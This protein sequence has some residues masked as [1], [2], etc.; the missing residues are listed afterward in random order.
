VKTCFAARWSI[1]LNLCVAAIAMNAI[2]SAS[3]GQEAG[4]PTAIVR[5][6]MVFLRT[7]DQD[8]ASM[9][10]RHPFGELVMQNVHDLLVRQGTS[11]SNSFVTCSLCAPSRATFLTGL[12]A[13]NHGVT[14]NVLP[15]GGYYRLDHS[16]T[17]PVWLQKAGYV[18]AHI[19]KYI[20]QYGQKPGVDP[21]T[22]PEV[23]RGATREIPPG[24]TRWFTSFWFSYKNYYI[25]DD[26]SIVHYG[27]DPEDYFT[28][29]MARKAVEFITHPPASGPF[30]LMVDF[31][32]PHNSGEWRFDDPERDREGASEEDDAPHLPVPAPRDDGALD[33]FVRQLPPS[34]NEADVS[35]KPLRIRKN[36]PLLTRE[37]I[38]QTET[39]YRKRLESLIAVDDAVKSICD[40]LQAADRWND[41]YVFFVS[42]NGFL[43]GEHRITNLK[44]WAYEESIRVPLVIRGPNVPAGQVVDRLVTNL[45]YTPTIVELAH[46]TPGFE[47]EGRSLLPLLAKPPEDA[48]KAA[49]KPEIAWRTDFLIEAPILRLTGLRTESYTYVEYDLD[50]FDIIAERELYVLKPDSI[51][52]AGDPF[53]LDNQ[54]HNK[55]YAGL[56]RKLS[57]R[58]AELKDGRGAELR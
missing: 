6:N 42:D 57:D 21:K 50:A 20:N 10:E 26:G 22:D 33:R 45:D 8:L 58:V 46:A 18:T 44:L 41:T 49:A 9:N 29:V 28:D 4:A 25:N 24:W 32:A 43:Q 55:A 31:I 15:E 23:P 14:H 36:M 52:S 47:L 5:P 27:D 48:K 30:F 37:K 53:E 11:F 56:I 7:D 2:V 35:G 40:A 38:A 51:R 3:R 1:A 13:H 17:L 19:G 39:R 54:S 16:N 34:F 12:Y